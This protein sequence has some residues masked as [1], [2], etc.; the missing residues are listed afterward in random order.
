MPP[1]SVAE[2]SL[3]ATPT[4]CNLALGAVAV[5]SA[6][7]DP[8]LLNNSATA[9][10]TVVDLPGS[11][12]SVEIDRVSINSD[13]LR[14]SWPITCVSAGL[15]A[16]PSLVPPAPWSP[17]IVPVVVDDGQISTILPASESMEYF[18][19]ASP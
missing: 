6:T 1:G 2:F 17:I 9:S 8:D 14:I 11:L 10:V 12:W 7:T 19:M 16:T 13:N 5:T 3:T 15:E 18:R 4:N